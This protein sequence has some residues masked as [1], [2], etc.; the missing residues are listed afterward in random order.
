MEHLTRAGLLT[1]ESEADGSD[2]ADAVEQKK[3]MIVCFCAVICR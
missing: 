2:E 1:G 3:D